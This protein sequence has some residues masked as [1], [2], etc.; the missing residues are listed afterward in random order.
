M[1]I[2]D[3]YALGFF[4]FLFFRVLLGI[5]GRRTN[6]TRVLLLS[7][8]FRYPVL[9]GFYY[10]YLVFLIVSGTIRGYAVFTVLLIRASLL[11][12]S[13]LLFLVGLFRFL[14]LVRLNGSFFFIVS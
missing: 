5:L 6:K 8:L 14:G 1:V 9:L 10:K 12:V 4:Y 3:Y 11:A 2:L 13:Y 7:Y